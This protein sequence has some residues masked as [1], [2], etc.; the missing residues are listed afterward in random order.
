M[1]RLSDAAQAGLLTIPA[2][3]LAGASPMIP[4]FEADTLP[5][6]AGD[7][8]SGAAQRLEACTWRCEPVRGMLLL[9]TQNSLYVKVQACRC[10]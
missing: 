2:R 3:C 10:A 1:C 5:K 7:Q 4:A 6:L 9:S 8:V